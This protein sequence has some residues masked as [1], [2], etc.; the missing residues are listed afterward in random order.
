MAT[1]AK[2]LGCRGVLCDGPARDL[3]EIR[4]IGDFQLLCTGAS[5]GHGPQ[6][7]QAIQVPVSDVC[8]MDISPGEIIHMDEN[9][10]TKL[11][12]DRVG[13]VLRNATELQNAEDKQL[14][15]VREC[16]TA[17]EIRE[18]LMKGHAYGDRPR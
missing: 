6:S 14:A 16:R 8:G 18:L 2:A 15:R 4:E 11:P 7:V 9:G 10:A 1:M 5:P 12:P 17:A 3:D 13:D